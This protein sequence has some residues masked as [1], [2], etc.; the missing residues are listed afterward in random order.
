MDNL[1]TP[2]HR[3]GACDRIRNLSGYQIGVTIA[4]C[5]V[6]WLRSTKIA[7]IVCT[8]LFSLTLHGDRP[9]PKEPVTITFVDPEWSKDLTDSL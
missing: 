5:K 9:I 8:F 6:S 2:V 7:G 1:T 4:I 3:G